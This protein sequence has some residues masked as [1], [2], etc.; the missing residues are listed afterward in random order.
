MIVNI[1]VR[2]RNRLLKELKPFLIKAASYAGSS[3]EFTDM[4]NLRQ[5]SKQAD[6]A[7]QYGDKREG[8]VYDCRSFAMKYGLNVINEHISA[9]SHHPGLL[10]NA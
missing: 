6:I 10:R 7:L 2:S 3:Y 4:T 1:R 8:M 9:H 5:Y